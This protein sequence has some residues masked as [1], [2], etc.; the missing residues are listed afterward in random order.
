MRTALLTLIL[1]A[2]P[3]P[4]ATAGTDP[5]E[6]ARAI[7]EE[8][9]GPGTR[10]RAADTDLAA[11]A[12][13]LASR[14]GEY[15]EVIRQPVEADGR[16]GENLILLQPPGV[17]GAGWIVVLAH[18]DHLG[19]GEP[20][21]PHAGEVYAGADDNASGCAVL[22]LAAD[23][24]LS[25]D[26]P[27]DRGLAFVLTT[28]E[29]HGLAGARAFVASGPL[30]AGSIDAA[31]NLDTVG[32]LSSSELTVFGV[33][34]A[35]VFSAALDGLN[36]VFR[37]PLQK[38]EQSSGSSDDM[39]FV[40][41]SIPALH[42]FTGAWPQYHR[43]G[44]TV[45]H[46]DVEGLVDLAD[47]TAELV[48]YLARTETE[49]EYV[50]TTGPAALADPERATEERRRV[51]FGSI[52][53][54][55]FDGEGVLLSGV[56]PGS[57]AAEAGLREGDRITGFGGTPVADLTDYSEAMKRY[58][59]G[60]VVEVEFVRDGTPQRVEVTLVERR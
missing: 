30:D 12:D 26:R 50:E 20:S 18:Y 3:A 55:Q 59:P 23:E 44:D 52:P 40:E 54:F 57:P 33:G 1:L 56:L 11:A 51:S 8:L 49:I 46:I 37:F 6:E 58:A 16:S 7:V 38:V 53:D 42:L 60:D 15:G 34:S 22:L 39:A 5:V 45:D 10:G 47:F 43:P 24:L 13:E 9:A 21:G 28:L 2:L 19:V 41:A 4:G 27:T 48:E 31:V 29:E 36:T 35:R 14:L 25:A 17:E 32:R